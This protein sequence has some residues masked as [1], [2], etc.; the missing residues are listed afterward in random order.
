MSAEEPPVAEQDTTADTIP[1]DQAP[2][3]SPLRNP[4][5]RLILIV[6]VLAIL[7]GGGLWF[8]RYEAHGKYLQSTNDAYV[9]SDAITVSPKVGG[10]VDQV[11]VVDNQQVRAGDP[12]VRIDPRDYRAQAEQYRAQVDVAAANAQGVRAQISEQQAVIDQSQA[13]L[14]VA[15]S[16]MQFARAQTARY[17]PLAATGAE[18]GERLAQLRDQERQAEAQAAAARAAVTSAQ[19]RI[20]SL[21]AQIGQAQSQGKAAEAQLASANVNLGSTIVR[22]SSDGRVGDKSV[23]LGQFVQPGLRLMSIVPVQKLYVSANFKE[24]QLGLM[25]VG[26]PVTLKVD[27]LDGVDLI[28]RIESISP[29]TGAQFSLLPPQNATGNFTKIVQRVPVRVAIDVGPETRKLLVPGM[30]VT[31]TVDT[32]SARDAPKQIERE[33]DDLNRRQGK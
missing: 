5:I 3:S 9:Q 29:G 25:R 15:T 7:I 27:A 11:Y 21:Q 1:A 22:A 32:I 33:Q 20:G 14:A 4:L 10:Y 28:G 19:R 6:V 8:W 16:A 18:T 17:A 30:S 2:R 31:V 26:Q 13:Q 23:Q 24:T 12:L